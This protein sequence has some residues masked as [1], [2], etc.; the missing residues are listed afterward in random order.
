MGYNE[1]KSL[2]QYTLTK[3]YRISF[4]QITRLKRNE[5]VSAHKN[6]VSCKILSCKVE[7]HRRLKEPTRNVR[8]LFVMD[9]LLLVLWLG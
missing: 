4:A 6:E 8:F 5:S 1:E 7:E 3:Q 2:F 9:N